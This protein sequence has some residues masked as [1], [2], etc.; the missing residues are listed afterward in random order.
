MSAESNQETYPIMKTYIFMKIL[1][2]NSSYIFIFLFIYI[3]IYVHCLT[4]TQ[5]TP[6]NGILTQSHKDINLCTYNHGHW[7]ENHWCFDRHIYIFSYNVIHIYFHD[8]CMPCF[9]P[10]LSFN[11]Q[12]HRNLSDWEYIYIF[13]YVFQLIL[14]FYF[15]IH[16]YCYLC[17]FANCKSSSAP[18]CTL[19]PNITT[20]HKSPCI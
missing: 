1:L 9:N 12:L 10:H 2:V 20:Q 16:L 4:V 5:E 6:Y 3:A 18:K 11:P 17:S 7:Y 19:T 15:F 8:D 14:H 13:I